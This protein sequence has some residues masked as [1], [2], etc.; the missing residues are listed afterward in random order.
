MEK[1]SPLLLAAALFCLLSLPAS[2]SFAA[3]AARK[4][5]P[6]SDS[7]RTTRKAPAFAV[8]DAFRKFAAKHGK[9][10]KVRY[11]PR[12][13]LPEAITGGRTGRYPG[14]PEAVASAFFAENKDLLGVDQPSLRLVTNKEFMGVTHLQYQQ[15][16]DGLPVEFS[17]ARVHVS[18]AGEILGYQGKFEPVTEVNSSPAVSE[19]AAAAAAAADLGSPL[20]ISKT[21]LVFFPDEVSGELK[22][23]WKVRGRGRGLWVYYVDAA[24]GAVLLKYDDLRRICNNTYYQTLGTSSAAVYAISPVPTGESNID[25][26]YWTQPV[27]VSLRDQYVWVGGYSTYTVTSQYGDYC[28]SQPGKV[29]SSFKGPYF[30]VSNF[31]GLPAHWDNGAGKWF[32]QNTPVQTPHPYADATN[33]PPYSVTLTDTWSASNDTLA[34][35][36]PR[37]SAFDTGR[38]QSNGDISDGDVVYV[39]NPALPG[40]TEVGAYIGKRLTSFFGASVESPSYSL[41]LRTDA[42]SSVPNTLNGFSVDISSYLVLTDDP[43]ITEVD[44]AKTSVFWSSSPALSPGVTLDRSRG[45]IAALA[46]PNAFY[47]LNMAHAYFGFLNA[48]PNHGGQP[49]ADLS[50]RVAVMIHA[51]GSDDDSGADNG[52]VN[53]YYDLEHDN[54]IVGVGEPDPKGNYRNFALDGTIL[55]HEYTHLVINRI[56]PIINFGEFGAISEGL[57]DYFSL[58]SFW[59]EGYAAQDTLGTFVD[60]YHLGNTRNLS[61]G[62]PTG[63]RK[64]PDNWWGEVHEDGLM[65]SQA[66]YDLNKGAYALG[67]YAAGIPRADLFTYAALFYF[68]DNY[69]NFYDAFKD[70]C[71]QLDPANCNA[72]MLGN[73]TNAFAAHGISGG[74]GGDSYETSQGAPL[75]Q[76]NNGP[77]CAA[78]ISSL[79]SLSATV[80]PLGD[81]DYY[82]LPVAAGNFTV[83]LNL[84]AASQPDTYLAYSMFLF[85]SQR[86]YAAEAV[87]AVYNSYGGYCP[88]SGDCLTLS[89]DIT[90]SY[91]APAAAR[92]Y[93]VVSGAPNR[94]Y[95]N[96][97]VNS[98]APYSLA[99]SR[100]P[101]GGAQA[102]VF[103]A[104]FDSDE[105]NFSVPFNRFPMSSALSSATL[106]GAE[107]VFE[108]ALLRDHK[109]E[110]LS[111]TRT[112]LPGSY[113]LTV[114]GTFSTST[115]GFGRPTMTGRV[116]LQHG[117]S[118]R[119]PGAGTIYLE[120]FGRNHMGNVTS[121]GVSNSMNLSASAAGVTA[122]NNIIGG[123][124]GVATIKCDTVSAGTISVKVYTQ[125]GS[126][127]K[128]LWDG[129]AGAGMHDYDWDGTNSSGGKAASGIYFVK[130]TGPG[131]NKIVKVAVVR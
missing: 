1:R 52:M 33:Y 75:C 68:P 50:K 49:A 66:L 78:D 102:Q 69:A 18:A 14:A 31:S 16:K 40:A 93:L 62:A 54:I 10:W 104:S 86:D 97:V 2:F 34:K 70:A 92:Y 58:A 72:T 60:P 74:A 115:D 56:Y 123:A 121:L 35:V 6:L 88:D 67:N 46:E 112:N 120:V 99:V 109:Y 85:D 42:L 98:Q 124:G 117:F 41:E 25:S 131:L 23:A 30:S 95:G 28:S 37:F 110:P 45:D 130:T 103:N 21:E 55:R 129:A 44:T 79:P 8:R 118:A 19:Q 4:L 20:R 122:Y 101:A 17:Y 96:S 12:T 3:P 90:L 128:T 5:S 64:M 24:T 119:Y 114:P 27:K 13:A 51:Y 105:I 63:L 61:G 94:Y 57:A 87:P 53:A 32:T 36:M 73:I 116:R 125:S 83:R 39:H 59:R 47:H 11:S 7:L 71:K 113:L 43:A 65:L 38:L 106:T 48:D 126:L 91:N 84:P 82:S 9:G 77:E 81:V 76:N 22:L 26:Q 127:V 111:L 80:Y 29:F 100:N 107:Q 108:Y 15:Y 89:P